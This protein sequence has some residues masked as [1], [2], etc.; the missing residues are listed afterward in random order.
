MSDP[1]THLP[2]FEAD[3][4]YRQVIRNSHGEGAAEGAAGARARELDR[5]RPDAQRFEH[6]VETV[7]DRWGVR[8]WPDTDTEQIARGKRDREH[9]RPNAE[10]FAQ[11]LDGHIVHHDRQ[12]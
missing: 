10:F 12:R 6:Y 8:P 5:V 7:V 3:R 1:V 11:T 4:D 9:F 2:L